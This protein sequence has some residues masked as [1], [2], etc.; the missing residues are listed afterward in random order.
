MF[1]DRVWVHIPETHAIILMLTRQPTRFL[2]N[3]ASGSYTEKY[4][5]QGSGFGEP[6]FRIDDF[7]PKTEH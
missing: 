7:F 3:N 1:T 6:T 5:T 4:V 2:L